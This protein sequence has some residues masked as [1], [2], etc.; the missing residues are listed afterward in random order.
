MM[1][2]GIKTLV[3]L[4]AAA[5]ALHRCQADVQ[6]PG[7]DYCKMLARDIAGRQHGTAT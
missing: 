4:L 7:T 2:R 1:P 5:G 6:P 3:C